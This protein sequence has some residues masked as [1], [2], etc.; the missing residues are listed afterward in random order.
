MYIFQNVELDIS[1]FKLFYIWQGS[2]GQLT[3][4]LKGS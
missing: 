4:R 3:M 1:A 2:G